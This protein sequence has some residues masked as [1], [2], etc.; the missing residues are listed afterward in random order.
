MANLDLSGASRRVRRYVS[1]DLGDRVAKVPTLDT[2]PYVVAKRAKRACGP[3]ADSYDMMVEFLRLYI[4]DV[5]DV[6]TSDE[7]N[8]IVT[9]I[10]APAEG[11]EAAQA[12]E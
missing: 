6:L 11:R 2:L 10:S 5:V 8:T 7:F 12:G 4:G 9:A 3:D 1:V